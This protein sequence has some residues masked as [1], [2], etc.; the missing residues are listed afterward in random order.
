LTVFPPDT[1]PRKVGI[2]LANLQKGQA[3]VNKGGATSAA[4]W[5]P[6]ETQVNAYHLHIAT[7]LMDELGNAHPAIRDV[8]L[9]RRLQEIFGE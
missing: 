9:A 7:E 2:L 3:I 5:Y 6:I 1:N 4:R 8:Y